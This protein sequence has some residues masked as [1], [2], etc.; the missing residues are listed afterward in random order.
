MT[1]CFSLEP[2]GVNSCVLPLMN[3]HTEAPI[4]PAL[5]ADNL[6]C[7]TDQAN[8]SAANTKQSALFRDLRA[9][10]PIKESEETK[11]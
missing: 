6:S 2:L 5:A 4:P 9:V 10:T 11:H 1:L 7:K 3:S 8:H